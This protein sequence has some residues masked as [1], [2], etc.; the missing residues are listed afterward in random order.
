M[1]AYSETQNSQRGVSVCTSIHRCDNIKSP[2]G[3][4]RQIKPSSRKT[5][6]RIIKPNSGLTSSQ[7]SSWVLLFV[8]SRVCLSD[9]RGHVYVMVGLCVG[10]LMPTAIWLHLQSLPLRWASSDHRGDPTV[11]R[12]KGLLELTDQSQLGSRITNGLAFHRWCPLLIFL[13]SVGAHE[14]QRDSRLFCTG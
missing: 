3:Q 11:S 6:K 12:L 9:L 14:E 1:A 7:V 10:L 4:W 2:D 8:V 5:S 13:L